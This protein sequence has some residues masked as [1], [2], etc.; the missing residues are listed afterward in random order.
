MHGVPPV[1]AAARLAHVRDRLEPGKVAWW[2]SVYICI[3]VPGSKISLMN[4][5]QISSRA[6]SLFKK[7][8]SLSASSRERRATGQILLDGAHLIEAYLE[9]FGA[10]AL[11]IVSAAD[12]SQDASV[13]LERLH[14]SRTVV[15]PAAMFAEISPVTA[16]TGIM[17]L[18]AIPER[19]V[20][21]TVKLALMLENIQDPGNLG[22]I[23]RNAAAANVDVVYLSTGCTEAWSPKALRGGQGAHFNLTIVEQADLLQEISRFEG[24]SYAAV[25]GGEAL[26]AMDLSGNTAFLVGNEG[27]GLSSALVSAASKRVTIPLSDKVESLNAA[28]ATAV[29]LFERVR[30]IGDY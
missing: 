15:L 27:S 24:N 7:L 6:N 29:C 18:V 4:H 20:P 14:D 16:P 9:T 11:V 22:S 13:L 8:R 28:A 17:A 19:P 23:L 2:F 26:Y 10:P 25:L 21:T 1:S 12:W 30:Q 3:M 5:Q